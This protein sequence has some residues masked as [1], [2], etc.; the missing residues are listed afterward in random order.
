MLMYNTHF[1]K[2]SIAKKAMLYIPQRGY[3]MNRT[4]ESSLMKL[5]FCLILE[6]NNRC[7][8][9]KHFGISVIML[10]SKSTYQQDDERLSVMTSAKKSVGNLE[11]THI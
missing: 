1:W 2:R 8:Y 10:T 7:R 11:Y 3:T 4:F 5:F 6:Y 9:W